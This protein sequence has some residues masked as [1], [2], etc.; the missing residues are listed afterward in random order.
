MLLS[1]VKSKRVN[2]K[3]KLKGLKSRG[4][5]QNIIT[6]KD[7]IRNG[8]RFSVVLNEESNHYLVGLMI[9]NTSGL[10]EKKFQNKSGAVKYFEVLD[11][12]VENTSGN[13][14]ITDCYEEK[15]GK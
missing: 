8:I 3:K 14:I 12:Y 15:H 7:F 9:H 4:E 1:K 10:L 11:E 2:I 5:Y 6:R 13:E